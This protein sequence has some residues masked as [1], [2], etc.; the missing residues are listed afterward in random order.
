MEERYLLIST[1][2]H[3]G[4]SVARQLR[5]YC[6]RRHLEA[7]DEDVR[8]TQMHYAK[9]HAAEINSND[10]LGG[11]IQGGTTVAAVA[12]ASDTNTAAMKQRWAD[13]AAVEGLQ[14]PHARLRDMDAEG[15]AVDIIFAGGQNDE[16]LPFDTHPDPEMRAVG[17]EIFNRWMVDYCSADPLR[18][19]GV[20]QISLHDIDAAVKAVR[21]AKDEGFCSINF[22]SP[23]RDLLPYTEEAYE[24]FWR[25]CAELEMPLNTHGGGGDRGYWS[26]KGARWCSR[27]EGQF[28]ARRALWGLIFGGVF[29]RHPGLKLVL[30]EQMS[31]WVPHTLRQLDGIYD[32]NLVA[33]R[34]F[35]DELP[36]RPSEY[37]ARQVFVGNSFMSRPEALMR[38]EI[39][40]SNIM[41]GTDY[42]H[43]ESVYPL[44]RLA[45]RQAFHGLPPTEVA[46]I[47]GE[48]AARCFGFDVEALRPVADRIGPTVA[49]IDVPP[50]EQE[51]AEE[52]PPFC[53]A[54]RRY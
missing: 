43:A 45:L 12:L 48:N 40:L 21:K 30:T 2:S 15:V 54:F 6:E 42:P 36:L 4:P 29:E 16:M 27:A 11:E 32:D 33:F 19:K 1:D 9:A 38:N 22:P 47:L 20:A 50:T 13:A 28:M 49:E 5:E 37:W 31:S 39:G 46:M 17:A 10:P 24:P 7:F 44:T 34:G 23:R 8:S 3:V 41:Y 52:V 51:L 26:G 14:D 53:L 25:V 18:L 35:Q